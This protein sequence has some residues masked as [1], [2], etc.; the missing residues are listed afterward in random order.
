[1]VVTYKKPA[2]PEQ[3]L[4]TR[5]KEERKAAKLTQAT[6]ARRINCPQSYVSKVEAGTTRQ[7]LVGFV[8]HCTAIGVDPVKLL[9]AWVLSW[10]PAKKARA[11]SVPVA[12]KNR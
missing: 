4:G 7:G 2:T 1:M 10:N 9:A 6:I 8:R 12:M 5:L 11:K 3:L